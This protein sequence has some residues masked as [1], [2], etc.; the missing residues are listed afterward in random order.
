MRRLKEN[1]LAT[2]R[3]KNGGR[4]DWQKKEF[5]EDL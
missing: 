5:S 4:G 3:I 2:K 1:L